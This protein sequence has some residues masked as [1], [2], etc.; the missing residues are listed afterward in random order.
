MRCGRT[1]LGLIFMLARVVPAQEADKSQTFEAADVHVSGPGASG[2]Q[3]I[4]PDGRMEFHG[5]TLLRLIS[6]AYSMQSERVSGGPNWIDVDRYDV[7]AKAAPG[8]PAKTMRTM[9]QGLLAERFGLS[10]KNDEQPRP[11]YALVVGK[12][13]P[14]ESNGEGDSECKRAQEEG[15]LTL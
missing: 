2:D 1:I 11:V 8:T 5:A 10:V 15:M 14:K 13:G 7:I 3:G 9:L 12:R 6:F 4:S